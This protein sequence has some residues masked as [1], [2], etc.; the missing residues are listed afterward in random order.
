MRVHSTAVDP[1]NAPAVDTRELITLL[2]DRLED[3]DE[4]RKVKLR[5]LAIG[6]AEETHHWRLQLLLSVFG[7][8]ADNGPVSYESWHNVDCQFR[9]EDDIATG[10]IIT[11]WDVESEVTCTAPREFINE[12][13]QESGLSGLHLHDNWKAGE[14][15]KPQ[16]NTM[17]IGVS[18]F[19]LD[20]YIDIAI[21]S[22][23]RRQ[24]ILR[25]RG[26]Q[27]FEDVTRKPGLPLQ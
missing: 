19:D 26:G 13:T 2:L 21:S 25:S 3:F 9:D 24:C 16:Y 23:N 8:S 7:R 6:S 1:S 5:V 15:Q 14:Q 22:H 18:D 27:G 4:V 20:G 10:R 17:Q 12:V 11:S